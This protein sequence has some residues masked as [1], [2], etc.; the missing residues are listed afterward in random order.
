MGEPAPGTLTSLHVWAEVTW[1]VLPS[2]STVC[3]VPKFQSRPW[4]SKFRTQGTWG[5]Y[6]PGASLILFV[7]VLLMQIRSIP[8]TKLCAA[9]L[10]KKWSCACLKALLDSF[11]ISQLHTV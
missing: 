2:S 1:G 5:N 11:L 8:T 4:F 9:H 10:A 6:F 7:H 3:G